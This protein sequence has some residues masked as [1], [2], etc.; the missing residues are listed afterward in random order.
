MNIKVIGLGA[1]GNKAVA[2]LVEGNV[3]NKDQ[4]LLINSTLKDVP[5]G[6][7]ESAVQFT[8]GRGCG[9]DRDLAKELCLYDI[10]QEN[11]S[12]L[13]KLINDNDELVVLAAS[14]EGGTGSGSLPILAK[15]YSA[16]M[17]LPVH[18]FAFTGF[19]EDSRGLQNT[20]EFFQDMEDEFTVQVIS[21]KKYLDA[22]ESKT[23][24]EKAAND[25]FVSKISILIGNDIID[26][27]QNIDETDLFKVSTTNGYMLI[28]SIT[29]DSKMKNTDQ[30]DK[31]IIDV[32]DNT[33]SLDIS[34]AGIKR[35]AIFVNADSRK[36][37]MVDYKCEAIKKKLG[38]PYEIFTHIQYDQSKPETLSFILAGLNM[39]LEEVK[40]IYEK[41]K[42]ESSKI[43]TDK[44]KFFEFTAGIQKEDK[45][46]A[47]L[48]DMFNA[49]TVPNQRKEITEIAK[50]KTDF[51]KTMESSN[52]GFGRIRRRA[53]SSTEPTKVVVSDT[54]ASTPTNNNSNVTHKKLTR[55]EYLN[56]KF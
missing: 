2:S 32:I 50:D 37:E 1:A 54:P 9:K 42:N 7:K 39:P 46:S 20:I 24:A 47:F 35:I 8:D 31:A 12:C 33:K 19:E 22:Y 17:G 29:L 16:V 11:L 38:M 13:D 18:C 6:Y 49:N 21:N 3:V 23:K 25:D 4:V 10:Q 30:I 36:A 41:F 51:V 43:N 14:T 56:Q 55:E 28:D 44:D 27:E 45:K 40:E 26:S 48:S 15:Y 53:T 52:K 34:G 5:E